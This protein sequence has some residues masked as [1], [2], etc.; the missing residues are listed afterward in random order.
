MTVQAGPGIWIFLIWAWGTIDVP[1]RAARAIQRGGRNCCRMFHPIEA[2]CGIRNREEGASCL[3]LGNF[4]LE[5]LVNN[6]LQIF[7]DL[8]D[9]NIMLVDHH[10][11][12]GPGI[13][14]HPA[15]A[16]LHLEAAKTTDLDVP[17][18]L[19]SIDDSGDE[20]IYHR[21]C[22][23]FCQSCGRCNDINNVCFSQA[24]SR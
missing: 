3:R 9:R 8:E 6:M 19:Q 2:R 12:A 21:F 24:A 4:F 10:L 5:I 22:F 18:G 14:S 7:G 16:L 11:F 23:H 17:S 20:S 13:P 15:L 1:I